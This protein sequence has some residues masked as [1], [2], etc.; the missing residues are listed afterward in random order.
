[1]VNIEFQYFDSCPNVPKLEE[2]LNI[3]LDQFEGNVNLKK[4][5][6]SDQEAASKFKFRG[7]PTLIINNLDFEFMPEPKN[8]T[9]CCRIYKNG[10]PSSDDILKR[11]NQNIVV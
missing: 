10:L 9:L 1:M 11:L 5:K 6:I 8:P 2:E 7:S 4:I 3:A